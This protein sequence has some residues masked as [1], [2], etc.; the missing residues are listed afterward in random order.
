MIKDNYIRYAGSAIELSENSNSIVKCNIMEQNDFG[1]SVGPGPNSTGNILQ[2]NLIIDGFVGI[3]MYGLEFPP[4]PP[5]PPLIL[6]VASGNMVKNN[7]VLGNFM[8]DMAE[9]VYPLATGE[10]Y[11]DPSDTCQNAWMKNQFVT[12][13]GPSNCIGLPVELDEADVCALDDDD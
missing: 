1:I 10:I 5:N 9:I 2:G 8:L 4:D 7:V 11:V 12:E 3:N 6:P 13:M